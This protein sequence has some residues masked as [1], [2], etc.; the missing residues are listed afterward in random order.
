MDYEPTCEL[1]WELSPTPGVPPTLQQKW[2]ARADE[3]GIT[4]EEWRDIPT[5]E[6]NWGRRS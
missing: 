2:V 5:F 6:E 3:E 4:Y 1:R